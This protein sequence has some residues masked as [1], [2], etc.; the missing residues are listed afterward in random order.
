MTPATSPVGELTVHFRA[1]AGSAFTAA[2]TASMNAVLVAAASGKRAVI[3]Q[4]KV[5]LGRATYGTGEP[6]ATASSGVLPV[7]PPTMKP[8]SFSAASWMIARIQL[9]SKK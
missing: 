5:G 7:V 9:R 8:R 2:S 4:V 1:P 6:N 3:S